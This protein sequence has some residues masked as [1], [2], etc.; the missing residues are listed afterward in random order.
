MKYL[1]EIKDGTHDTPSYIQQ[2]EK[3]YPLVTSKDIRSGKINFSECKHISFEDY[4]S[5]NKRSDVAKN[6]IIM[7]M[8]GTVG[9]SIVVETDEPFSIK[10]VAIFKT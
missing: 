10:N 9:G 6:D 1:V 8:I 4:D 7:P 2:S 3:S 5:I